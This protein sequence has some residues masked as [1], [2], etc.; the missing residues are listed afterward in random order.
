MVLPRE[1]CLLDAYGITNIVDTEQTAPSVISGSALFAPTCLSK[2][3][4]RHA[5]PRQ[6]KKKFLAPSRLQ[7]GIP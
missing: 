1:M 4:D 3:W 6:K 7:S 5:F 2:T